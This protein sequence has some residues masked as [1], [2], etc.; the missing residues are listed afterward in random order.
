MGFDLEHR[1]ASI[2]ERTDHVC[3]G[4]AA[5]RVD[6]L[7]R[8]GLFDETLG[9]GYDNDMSYRLTAAGSRLSFCR[10]ARSLHRWREGLRGYWSSSTASGT[11]DSISL[12]STRNV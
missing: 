3:T 1:Y 4:N 2:G 9:Y 6:T 8:V 10:E 7:S 5:Y 11:G 12:R